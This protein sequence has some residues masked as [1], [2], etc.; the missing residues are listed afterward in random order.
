MDYLQLIERLGVL[1]R[2]YDELC[3][4][5]KT[6]DECCADIHRELVET[7]NKLSM[8]VSKGFTDSDAPDRDSCS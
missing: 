3:A 8:V 1:L 7:H 5:I 4:K 6:L 2:E